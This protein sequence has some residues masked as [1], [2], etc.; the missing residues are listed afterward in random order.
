MSLKAN[1]DGFLVGEP[2]ET[3]EDVTED[4]STG[5]IVGQNTSNKLLGGIKTDVASIARA[6]GAGRSSS[7]H[8]VAEPAGRRGASEARGGSPG[9]PAVFAQR[10]GG[11]G[12]PSAHAT[13]SPAG[14]DSKGRFSAVAGGAAGA[15]DPRILDKLSNVADALKSVISE[16]VEMAPS[17]AALKE[18]KDVV[19]PTPVAANSVGHIGAASAHATVSPVGR[20]SKEKIDVGDSEKSDVAKSNL[21]LNKLGGAAD[22]LKGLAS[23]SGQMDPALAAVGEIRN[24]VEPLGRGAFALLGK[25]EARKNEG[26]FRKILKSL[27]NLEKKPTGS[28][29]A[30]GV[31]SGGGINIGLGGGGL[32]GGLFKGG[33]GLLKGVGGLLGGLLKGGGGALKG[34]GGL[35]KRIPILGTLLA[36]GG[37]LASMF[38]SD[39]PSK[40]ADENRTEKYKGV[41]GSAGMVGGG[42]LGA[43]LGSALGPVGTVVGGYL[44]SMAGELIG[45][46][47]GEWTKTLVDADIPGMIGK[48]WDGFM[49]FIVANW[50]L[51]TDKAKALWE[52]AKATAHAGAEKV[53]EVGNKANDAIKNTTGIDV[54]KTAQETAAKVS[55]SAVSAG[56]KAVEVG[57]K[58][59]DAAKAGAV[60]AGSFVAENA[61]KLVPNTVKRLVESV[62]TKRVYETADG[63]TETRTGGSVSWRNNNPGNLK[64]ENSESADTTVK[65]RRTKAQALAAA[66]ARYDGVVDLD[67][68]GNAIFATED[69]GRAAKSALLKGAHGGKTI[70][71][72]LP[73]YAVSDYSGKANHAAYAAGI[74]KT[75]DA[76]GVD[77][78]GKKIEDLKPAEMNAL[79]D[80]MKR[81][82]GYKVG[83]VA[84]VGF[85][86]SSGQRV[87]S[88]TVTAGATPVL[89]QLGVLSSVPTKL[90]AMPEINIPAPSTEK[91]RPLMV[92]IRQ[93]IGQDVG[94]RGIAHIVSGGMGAVA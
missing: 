41:G 17:P 61:P 47:V 48:K 52:S 29:V 9:Q 81:V 64:F 92:S 2:D 16:P 94:D 38:G 22:A 1:N 18:V 56:N 20:G 77:L 89:A 83:G 75:G 32:L 78:R 51:V 49:S 88:A 76:Q 4:M 68:W 37:A 45:E 93:P 70:E 7:P 71:E 73:K 25:S 84:T 54:K 42:M 21:L 43:V 19:A 55:D 59:A 80:G 90:P 87:P 5:M 12:A 26:W 14:R 63:Q 6:L 24:V 10:T 60:A 35:L 34:A 31:S 86:T 8:L 50:P 33:G 39:D 28:V 72:M 58:A 69:K 85:G 62:G 30:G 23:G 3:A 79:L 44:G 91:E 82:E 13:V 15:D 57:G 27:T 65:S 46:K 11:F 36:G 66:Q 67:Q 40:S 74:Y 53:A